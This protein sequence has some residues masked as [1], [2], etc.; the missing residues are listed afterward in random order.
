MLFMIMNFNRYSPQHIERAKKQV[1]D[2]NR[3]TVFDS[4]CGT[5][6]C[7]FH[8]YLN[9]LYTK[10]FYNIGEL[11]A[12]FPDMG[13]FFPYNFARFVVVNLLLFSLRS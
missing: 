6:C 2:L 13:N 9:C 3:D 7:C 10:V 1:Q 12:L 8:C 4:Q 5:E 11:R